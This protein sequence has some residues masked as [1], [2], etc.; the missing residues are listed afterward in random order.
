MSSSRTIQIVRPDVVYSGNSFSIPIPRD[1]DNIQNPAFPTIEA[2]N[3]TKEEG[4]EKYDTSIDAQNMLKGGRENYADFTHISIPFS[5][6]SYMKGAYICH[7]GRSPSKHL[8]FTFTSSTGEKTSKQYNFPDW[9]GCHWWL[10]PI[11]LADVVLCEITGRGREGE[12]FA[13]QSLVFF[14][15]ETADETLGRETREHLLERL[16]SIESPRV[17]A[18]FVKEADSKSL[19]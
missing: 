11:D 9:R 18:E 6:A 15:E 7:G 8:I 4:D 5:S 1:A 10:L 12:C 13:I 19:G 2:R 3:E 14:R 17:K 16:W